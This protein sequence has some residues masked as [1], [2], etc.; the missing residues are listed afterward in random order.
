MATPSHIGLTC[1]CAELGG[2]NSVGQNHLESLPKMQIPGP[3]PKS[4][5][6]RL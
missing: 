5:F 4:Q 1:R 3:D 2:D 6:T